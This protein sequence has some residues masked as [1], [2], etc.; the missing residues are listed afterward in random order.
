MYGACGRVI[1]VEYVEASLPSV[2]GRS[3]QERV[4]ISIKLIHLARTFTR[5]EDDMALYMYDV[6]MNN[7]AVDKRGNVKL[8]DCEHVLIV[9]MSAFNHTYGKFAIFGRKAGFEA[10]HSQG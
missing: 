1:V 3:W 4:K 5:T 8:I 7:F 9:D 10:T 2:L 6:V